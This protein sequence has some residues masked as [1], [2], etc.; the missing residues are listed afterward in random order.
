MKTKERRLIK[1]SFDVGRI[2]GAIGNIAPQEQEEAFVETETFLTSGVDRTPG[3]G[4]GRRRRF[5]FMV[6][7]S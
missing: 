4:K 5:A 6:V 3:H 7:A 2:L 1:R